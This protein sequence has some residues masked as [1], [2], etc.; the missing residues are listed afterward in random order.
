MTQ[1][2]DKIKFNLTI[3]LISLIVVPLSIVGVLLKGILKNFLFIVM[4]ILIFYFFGKISFITSLV[5]SV[6]ITAS[7]IVLQE[8]KLIYETLINTCIK[9]EGNFRFSNIIEA[10]RRGNEK[11]NISPIVLKGNNKY[12]VIEYGD[13][14]FNPTDEK[15]LQGFI[16]I[17]NK[18]GE[19]VLD[20]NIANEIVNLFLFWRH[21]YFN[22]IFGKN[23][24]G[25]KKLYFK[26]WKKF[27]KKFKESIL[28]RQKN[29]YEMVSNLRGEK[30]VELL[31]ELDKEVIEQS[32]FV[33]RKIELSFDILNQIYTIFL[34]PSAEFY[35]EIY[36]KIE[37]LSKISQEENEIW[38]KRLRTWGNLYEF[39]KEKI[40]KLAKPNFKL[41]GLGILGDLIDSLFLKQQAYPVGGA[42]IVS[43]A[44]EGSKL[45]KNK[46]VK[47]LNEILTH[48]KFGI[49][50]IKN[51]IEF[52]NELKRTKEKY[53][54]I[55]SS[56]LTKKIRNLD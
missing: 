15:K 47:Y 38:S 3:F 22:P 48:H 7:L 27:Q 40:E 19:L 29:N 42:T 28:E 16:V 31:K 9:I 18:D 10:Y 37:E 17:N 5:Y 21:I 43:L 26:F 8:R 56:D 20:K 51:N 36:E 1:Q 50:A 32:P 12:R 44:F 45:I 52:N 30:F 54:Q 13:Y 2:K 11:S 49:E 55:L 53:K 39:R 25:N 34:K 33:M 14:G 6:T 4:L 24:A 35:K 23:M 41:V 46:T